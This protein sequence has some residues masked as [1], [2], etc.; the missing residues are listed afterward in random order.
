MNRRKAGS[1]AKK[2]VGPAF[3]RLDYDE[4]KNPGEH[5]ITT[6]FLKT[7]KNNYDHLKADADKKTIK[8]TI[9]SKYYTN[10]QFNI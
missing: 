7:F 5:K 6:I 8:E 4:K 3:H 2:R 10:T 9:H 1:F